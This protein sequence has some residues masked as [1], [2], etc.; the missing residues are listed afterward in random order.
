MPIDNIFLASLTEE[1]FQRLIA[2]REQENK[3][4][5]FKSVLPGNGHEDH[6]NFLASF[7]SFA[8]TAGGDL[9]YGIQAPNGVA[10]QLLGLDGDL[11]AAINRLENIIRTGLQP[12][13]TGYSV[14]PISLASGRKLLVFRIPRS[15]GLPHRVTLGGHDKFY[16]RSS[17]G[18]YALDVSELRALFQLSESTADRIKNFRAE[19]VLSILSSQTPVP[20][21]PGPFTVIHVVPFNAFSGGQMFDVSRKYDRNFL[22]LSPMVHAGQLSYRHNMD[23]IVTYSVQR[24]P[25]RSRSYLQLFR[26]GI[27]ESV[28]AWNH[29]SGAG[30]FQQVQHH[31]RKRSSRSARANECLCRQSS[32]DIKGPCASAHATGWDGETLVFSRF[33]LLGLILLGVGPFFLS[34]DPHAH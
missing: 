14:V 28:L 34:V 3:F 5:E 13:V 16:G 30:N 1:H 19:R 31:R 24:A 2:D 12:R 15:W 9:I 29:E 23:G 22:P 20:L 8:N 32:D 11:D 17:A 18:K 10:E 27:I 4:I 6:K 26:S 21:A 25:A 33:I 7:S